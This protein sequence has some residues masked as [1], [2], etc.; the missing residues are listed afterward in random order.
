MPWLA[1]RFQEGGWPN[2]I[3][4]LLG[5][6]GLCVASA[7]LLVPLL[8]KGRLPSLWAGAASSGWGL[9]TLGFGVLGMYLGERAVIGAVANVNPVEREQILRLGFEESRS[10][11]EFALGWALVPILS[12]AVALLVA[13]RRRAGGEG[14][15]LP[16]GLALSGFVGIA[17]TIALH[18]RPLPGRDLAEDQ[19]ELLEAIERLDGDTASLACDRL[20]KPVLLRPSPRVRAMP[21]LARLATA[22]VDYQVQMLGKP[23]LAKRLG[24]PSP[25]ESLR[26]LLESE[27][28][29][30]PAAAALAREALA[31][32]AAPAIDGTG[33]P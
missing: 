2:W 17:A 10:P 6:I 25:A 5:T 20:R 30:S 26:E 31:K 18:E 33:R 7:A 1:Q 19:W 22:C 27:L 29:I 14:L 15:A 9:F 28:P 16:L 21:E 8:A 11:L 32:G 23:E 12:G 24:P 13:A 4:I 3:L